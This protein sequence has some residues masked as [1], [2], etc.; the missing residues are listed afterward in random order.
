MNEDRLIDIE[1]KIA[2]QEDL[3]QELNKVVCLQQKKIDQLEAI[4]KSLIEHIRS[5]SE[6]VAEGKGEGNIL[7]ERPPHY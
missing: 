4:C 2:F 1:T 5:L 3:V 7:D 6:A